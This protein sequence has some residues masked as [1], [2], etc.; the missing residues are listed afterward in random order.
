MIVVAVVVYDRFDNIRSWV[1][2]WNM[3]NTEG[4]KLV[5]IHNVENAESQVAFKE[6]CDVSGVCYISH[7]N[8]GY[9]I[10]RFQDVC[11]N[12]LEGFPEYETLLWCTDDTIPMKKD[13]IQ[14]FIKELT[15]DVGCVAMQISYEHKL[16]IRTTG[17]Y[18]RR[19]TA[20]KLEFSCDPII[21]KEDCWGFEHRDSSSTFLHQILNM[22]LNAVQVDDIVTSPMW[23][24]GRNANHTR[25]DEH[26]RE[27]SD[28]PITN[29]KVA[30]ICPIYNTYPEIVSAMINQTHQ[31]WHLYLVHDG[32]SSLDIKGI[33]D[34]AKDNRITYLETADRQ[35]NWGHYIRRDYL[36]RIKGSDFDFVFITNADNYHVPV[37]IEYLV[38][39]F[40]E[41]TVATYCSQMVHSYLSWGIIEC[42][43]ELGYLDAA[44]VMIR[45]EVACELGWKNIEAHSSDWLFFKSIIDKYGANKFKKIK[46][47]LLIH[48]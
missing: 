32:P 48:N 31:N 12:R 43:L 19:E 28:H 23:D 45:A 26:L 30:V 15:P 36:D 9:D 21:S 41:D 16:H 6:F 47:C 13:F 46:G 35:S 20:E 40:D 24:T 27:F 25:R 11:R 18:I 4:A 8:I 10:G 38:R 22:G 44:G 34:A 33:V 39:G 37:Y 17:F 5:I 29:K 1:R 42:R 14:R 2:A 3:C 7:E